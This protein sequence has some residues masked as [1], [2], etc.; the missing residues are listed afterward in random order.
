MKLL[1]LVFSPTY[2]HNI[3]TKV[4]TVE[5]LREWR[6][7]LSEKCELLRAGE[8]LVSNEGWVI[9]VN[10]RRRRRSAPWRTRIPTPRNLNPTEVKLG[11]P[12][13]GLRTGIPTTKGLTTLSL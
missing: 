9:L 6:I 3:L 2:V 4:S 13:A 12:A 1:E 10:E 5:C 8:E 7:V 11:K